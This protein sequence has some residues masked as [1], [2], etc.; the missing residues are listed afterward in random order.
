M[1]T[2]SDGTYRFDNVRLRQWTVTATDAQGRMRGLAKNVPV[3][4]NGQVATANLTLVGLGTVTGRVLNPDNSSAPISFSEFNEQVVT[5]QI[6]S[7]A[8]SGNRI[9]GQFKNGTQFSTQIPED[10]TGLTQRML[11]HK[12]DV[13]VRPDGDNITLLSIF[14]N[15]FPML[16]F[17]AVMIFLMRQ[18]QAGGGKA[19]G[20]GKSRAKML[21]ERQ[22]RVTFE[23]VAGVD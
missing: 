4:G 9:E 14:I 10:H 21:T 11:D 13:R 19:M 2:A 5:D 16:L 8:M 22:G 20:F 23:D 12:V 15:W 3:T 17:V 18:M 6:K 1:T 7:V